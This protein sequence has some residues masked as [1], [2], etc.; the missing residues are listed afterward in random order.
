MG[1]SVSPPPCISPVDIYSAGGEEQYTASQSPLVANSESSMTTYDGGGAAGLLSSTGR[2]SVTLR[3]PLGIFWD[4]ENCSVPA[5]VAAEDVA[6][7]VRTA[8]QLHSATQETVITVFAA[9]GDFNRFPRRLRE[10]CHRTGIS[11]FDVPNGRK[12]AADKAIMADVFLF[13]LDNPPPSTIFLISGDVDF[14]P[15]LHKL[16]Q[17][18]YNILLAVPVHV[19]VAPALCSAG[20]FVW[21]WPCLARGEGLVAAKVVMSAVSNIQAWHV[22]PPPC[23]SSSKGAAS[24]HSS[25]VMPQAFGSSQLADIPAC[26]VSP[27]D[28]DV[29]SGEDA[30]LT[31]RT[32]GRQ[33]AS[34][35]G[36]VVESQSVLPSSP[37]SPIPEQA[38]ES[39]SAQSDR[40]LY[41]EA[42]VPSHIMGFG[43]SSS[44]GSSSRPQSMVALADAAASAGGQHSFVLPG[45]LQGLKEQL[46]ELLNR[47]GGRLSLVRLPPEYQRLFGRP[48]YL[49]EYGALKVVQLVEKMRDAFAIT[50]TGYGKLIS[51]RPNFRR[52]PGYYHSRSE[53]KKLSV[54]GGSRDQSLNWDTCRRDKY[55]A[56]VAMLETGEEQGPDS[57]LSAGAPFSISQCHS[58]SVVCQEEVDSKK[59]LDIPCPQSTGISDL[60]EEDGDAP[61]KQAHQVD[62]MGMPSMVSHK[63]ED[64]DEDETGEEIVWKVFVNLPPSAGHWQ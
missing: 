25:S 33:A 1:G 50:G 7:N 51:L 3:R 9:Y 62:I 14:S 11:L 61:D 44:L 56:A 40:M 26:S 63:D 29:G 13:A 58:E 43:C 47:H 20:E 52:G 31:H 2:V 17:R 60:K 34:G 45:D 30:G 21:D 41:H 49:A 10:G 42:L 16:G 38:S 4:I 22:P 24:H 28:T 15:S 36:D 59:V 37:S 12:D 27:S 54:C 57:S 39:R 46:I 18:G 8:L 53:E 35:G 64:E 19:G 23:S 5:D 48:L 55:S 6:G 32:Y